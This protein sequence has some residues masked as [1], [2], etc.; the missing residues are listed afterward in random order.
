MIHRGLIELQRLRR[1]FDEMEP[2]LYRYPAID[3]RS[4]RQAVETVLGEAKGPPS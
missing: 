4:F 2:F 1:H 3:P